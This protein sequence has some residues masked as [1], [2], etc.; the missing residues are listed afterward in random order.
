[1]G[2]SPE[3]TNLEPKKLQYLAAKACGE[4]WS[5]NFR[6]MLIQAYG[7]NIPI[8][9]YSNWVQY[10]SPPKY[11][12]SLLVNTLK[13]RLDDVTLAYNLH[14]FGLNEKLGSISVGGVVYFSNLEKLILTFLEENIS[15]LE[16]GS[17]IYFNRYIFDHPHTFEYVDKIV[18]K[19]QV[20]GQT[21]KV[22]EVRDEPIVASFPVSFYCLSISEKSGWQS[23]TIPEN[24]E[25]LFMLVVLKD[26][27][28]TFILEKTQIQCSYKKINTVD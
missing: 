25:F 24:I 15:T 18:R 11:L 14:T 4:I 17:K 23:F 21:V 7:K 13:Q 1:M 22:S 28:K 8:S 20:D 3:S 5:F 9:T 6:S 10:S 2:L 26:Q 19:K 16:G 27:L 12:S